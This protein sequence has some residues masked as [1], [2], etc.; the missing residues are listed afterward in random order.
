MSLPS[1]IGSIDIVVSVV[2]S[3]IS[4]LWLK[5]MVLYLVWLLRNESF[6]FCC[7]ISYSSL[8]FSRQRFADGLFVNFVMKE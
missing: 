2:L 7:E 5:V 4:E 6:A 1:L 3:S 8:T